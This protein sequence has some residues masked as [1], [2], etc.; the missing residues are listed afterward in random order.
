MADASTSQGRS[1]SER[2]RVLAVASGG[3]HWLQLLRVTEGLQDHDLAFA[4]VDPSYAHDVPGCRLHVISDATRWNRLLLLKLLFEVAW[5]VLRERPRVVISTGA[6]PG[7]LA[8]FCGR[9]AGARTIWV[10]SIANVEEMSLSGRQARRFAHLWL[11][12]WPEV[13]AA[14]GARFEG[15]VL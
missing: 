14:A 8:L 11:S 7:L 4:T 6:A 10:D 5:I 2:L 13:A 15:S 1:P 3:G 9:L 12:Q